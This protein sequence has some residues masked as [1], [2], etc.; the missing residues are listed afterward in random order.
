[1]VRYKKHRRR[2]KKSRR[3]KSLKKFLL[4]SFLILILAGGGIYFFFFSSVL[5]VKEIEISGNEKVKEEELKGIIEDRVFKKLL[6]FSPKNIFFLDLQS[7]REEILR[8]FPQIYEARFK[9]KIPSKIVVEVEERKRVGL[10]YS[11]DGSYLIDKEGIIFEVAF[12]RDVSNKESPDL[13]IKSE[14]TNLNLGERVVEKESLEKILRI[15]TALDI[16]KIGVRDF[17]F[18]S[19]ERLDVGTL[20]GWKIYFSLT[21]DLDW[22]ITKLKLALEKEIPPESREELEYI[23]L[24]FEN[25]VYPKWTPF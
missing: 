6:F 23:D 14:K 11:K 1:M 25:M 21:Y 22:Q 12:P 5:D 4:I 15:Q 24:R 9:R 10:F 3:K 17:T 8:S 13:I 16:L 20:E 19:S 18:P 7:P 2:Y